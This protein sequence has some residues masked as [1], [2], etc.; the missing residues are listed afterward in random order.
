MYN[1]IYQLKEKELGTGLMS[2]NME[3]TYPGLFRS[4]NIKTQEIPKDNRI[5]QI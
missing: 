4:F 2:I 1:L 5:W 3:K